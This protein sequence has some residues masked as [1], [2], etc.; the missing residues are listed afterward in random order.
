MLED[1]IRF[2]KDLTLIE[3]ILQ[4]APS[5]AELI[6]FDKFPTEKTAEDFDKYERSHKANDHYATA[7]DGY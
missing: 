3:E 7:V 2:L 4:A 5:D 6:H 1:D